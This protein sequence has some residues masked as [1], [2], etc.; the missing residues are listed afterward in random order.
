MALKL[1]CTA[2]LLDAQHKRDCAK[3]KFTRCAVRKA[4]TGILPS[5]SGRQV[6]GNSEASS[7]WYFDHF[8]VTGG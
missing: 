6:A 4:L 2:S 8:F 3:N 7:L 5:Y 1:V